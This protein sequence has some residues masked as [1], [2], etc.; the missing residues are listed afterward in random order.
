MVRRRTAVSLAATALIAMTPVISACGSPHAG[1][2]AVVEN[3]T[4]SVSDLQSKVNAVRT[5]QEKSPQS[6]E[7][8]DGSGELTSQTLD[9]MVVTRVMDRVAKDAGV[10]VTRSDIGQMRTALETQLGGPATLASTLLTKYNVAPSGIDDFFRLQVEASKIIQSLGA[11]PGS[12]GGNAQLTQLLAKTSKSMRIDVNPR[13]GA[14][15]A[16]NARIGAT[17]EPWLAAPPAAAA[18]IQG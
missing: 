14:W 6:A 12:D 3:E 2:A 18:P 1:A 5:A 10:T 15:D 7:L 17:R 11:Q 4:I 9:T 16:A 8:I 13:Y